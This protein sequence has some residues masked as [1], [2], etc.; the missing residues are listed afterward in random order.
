M[1]YMKIE[2]QLI[3]IPEE[4]KKCATVKG[5]TKACHVTPA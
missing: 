5:L 1:P 4:T 2:L 3:G